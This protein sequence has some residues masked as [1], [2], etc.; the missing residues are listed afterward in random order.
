MLQKLRN[1]TE[2]VKERKR[3]KTNTLV[4]T[5]QTSQ[6]NYEEGWYDILLF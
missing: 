3:I 2:L 4:Y 6:S 5:A 1:Y